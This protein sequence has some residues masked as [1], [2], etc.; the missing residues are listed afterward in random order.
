[1]AT[2]Y[3]LPLSLFLS[4]LCVLTQ[5]TAPPAG[6]E[7]E[8]GPGTDRNATQSTGQIHWE[9]RTPRWRP[10]NESQ[11]IQ[12]GYAA[13]TASARLTVRDSADTPWTRTLTDSGPAPGVNAIRAQTVAG[14]SVSTV[15][16]NGAQARSIDPDLQILSGSLPTSFAASG[17]PAPHAAMSAPR[18]LDAAGNGGNRFLAGNIRFTG[19]TGLG[20]DAQGSQLHLSV[21]AIGPDIPE[22]QTFFLVGVGLLVVG[23]GSRRRSRE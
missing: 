15:A 11:P 4:L 3:L 2:R 12:I 19:L 18:V 7:R 17:P 16:P 21:N 8:I 5:R 1:M 14:Y 10:D 6:V 22:A 9:S 13:T 23:F 20:G